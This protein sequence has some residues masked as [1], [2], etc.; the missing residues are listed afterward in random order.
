MTSF[1]NKKSS[2]VPFLFLILL[3]SFLANGQDFQWARQ[4]G[5]RGTDESTAIEVDQE[6]NSYVIGESDSNSF[7]LNPTTTGSQIIDNSFSQYSQISDIYLIK[8]NENGDFLWG[9]TFGDIKRDQYAYE[10]KIGNCSS[11]FSFRRSSF[12]MSKS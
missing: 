12:S 6:G 1:F 7:D 5:D 8:Q 4:I 10:I 3:Y 9:K 11:Y 2:K